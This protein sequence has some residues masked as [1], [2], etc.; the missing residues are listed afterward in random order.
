M[1]EL[2]WA[3]TTKAL[4]NIILSHSVIDR[5]INLSI[6]VLLYGLNYLYSFKINTSLYILQKRA[7]LTWRA[8]S[9]SLKGSNG[10]KSGVKI[11]LNSKPKVN[12]I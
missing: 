3:W 12:L 8:R 2:E 9:A 7:A 5:C 11:D 1:D 4:I 10:T 6:E